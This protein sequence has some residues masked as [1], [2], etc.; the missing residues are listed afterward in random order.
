MHSSG[1][2]YGAFFR[3]KSEDAQGNTINDIVVVRDDNWAKGS[4]AFQNL[5][6]S[7]DAYQDNVL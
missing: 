1:I 7:E 5:V 3:K 4:D 2:I 6:D